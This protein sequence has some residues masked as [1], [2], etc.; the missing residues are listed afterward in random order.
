MKKIISLALCAVLAGC[1]TGYSQYG[2]NGGYESTMLAKDTFL[3]GFRGNDLTNATRVR[4]FAMLRSAELALEKGYPYFVVLDMGNTSDK[5]SVPLSSANVTTTTYGNYSHT[6]Y[7]PAQIGNFTSHN[8][9]I[10]FQ[11]FTEQTAPAN[12]LKAVDVVRELRTK[13]KLDK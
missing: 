3:V 13:Y 8:T 10:K 5:K 12:A 7:N 4:D 9:K 11:G 1:A 2:A 6:T